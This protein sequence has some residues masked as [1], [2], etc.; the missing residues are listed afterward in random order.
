MPQSNRYQYTPSVTPPRQTQG[1]SIVLDPQT[2]MLMMASPMSNS[3]AMTRPNESPHYPS[4]WQLTT[5]H[6]SWS[7][8][9]LEH[10]STSNQYPQSAKKP[11]KIK[12]NLSNAIMTPT[13]LT[14]THNHTNKINNTLFINQLLVIPSS[15]NEPHPVFCY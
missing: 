4:P 8:S 13:T 11:T 15:T 10:L 2:L 6:Y 5:M 14:P 7:Q 3:S 1:H 12:T 9:L